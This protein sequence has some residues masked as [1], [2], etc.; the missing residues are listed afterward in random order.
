MDPSRS[1]RDLI[2]R[3]HSRVPHVH[4]RIARAPGRSPHSPRH[5]GACRRSGSLVAPDGLVSRGNGRGHRVRWSIHSGRIR[6]L[7]NLVSQFSPTALAE[8]SRSASPQ[9]D[10]D[11]DCRNGAQRINETASLLQTFESAESQVRRMSHQAGRFESS[12]SLNIWSTLFLNAWMKYKSQSVFTCSTRSS[13][14]SSNLW[15]SRHAQGAWRARG[16][17]FCHSPP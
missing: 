1:R 17:L 15:C 16:T 4:W 12:S 2:L 6:Y 3:E 9:A 14:R 11:K 10:P 7:Q 8:C 5:F 13:V